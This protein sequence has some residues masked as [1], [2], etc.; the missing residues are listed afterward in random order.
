MSFLF[1]TLTQEPLSQVVCCTSSHEVWESLRQRFESNSTTRIINLRMQ[2]QQVRKD[3]RTM[4]NYLNSVKMYADQ[5]SA[6][7]EP[8]RYRDHLWY[9]L[10]G[11]PAEYDPVVTAVYSRTDQPSIE[12]VHQLLLNFDLR[13]ERRQVLD[14]IL[15][16]VQFSAASSGAGTTQPKPHTFRPRYSRPASS[17]TS[18]SIPSP[19]N[20]HPPFKPDSFSP[21]HPQPGVLG[22]PPTRPHASPFAPRWG[23]T[24]YFRPKPRCQIC[25][26][27]GHTAQTCF[28]RL[29][30]SS[31]PSFTPQ[32]HYTSIQPPSYMPESFAYPVTSYPP[33]ENT[34][35]SLNTSAWLVDS[36]AT[37]H[38]T[39]LL[40]DLAAAS[41]Y[42]GQ[43]DKQDRGTGSS[44]PRS[45]Q[46][47]N[48]SNSTPST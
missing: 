26:K 18:S 31:F 38:V 11:L 12:E 1:S 25:Y 16:Q 10:E 3:G 6:I 43:D 23:D 41:S 13:L 5:L 4:Q 40:S 21:Q 17:F 46:A 20:P 9:L 14:P 33:P 39:P 27:I 19:R 15:P 42:Q 7:G 30:P 24:A 48:S 45:V 29:S 32:T 2:M 8:V 44:T 37:H 36:G 28:H 35:S 34:H 22:R 47:S